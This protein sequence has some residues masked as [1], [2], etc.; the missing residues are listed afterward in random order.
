M[1]TK[2]LFHG[3][4]NLHSKLGHRLYH[5]N[6]ISN[7]LCP[8]HKEFYQLRINIIVCIPDLYLLQQS[9]LHYLFKVLGCSLS[10]Y[11]HIP[12]YKFYLRIRMEE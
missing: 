3:H 5:L 1:S 10:L 2:L 12:L 9:N 11:Y 4:Y 6:I 8:I 7:N